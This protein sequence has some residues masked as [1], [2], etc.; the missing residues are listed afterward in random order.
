MAKVVKN[1]SVRA[2]MKTLL[3]LS[4][5]VVVSSS[6]LADVTLVQH[7]FMGASKTPMVTTMCIKGG[8]VRSDNDTT[9]SVIMDTDTGDMTTL[10]HE[11][12][13]IIKMNTKELATLAG[14][15]SGAEKAVGGTK[16]TAT[17]QKEKIDGYDC[18]LYLSENM[19]M[20]VKMWLTEDY[21]GYEKLREELKVMAKM[22]AANAP[23]QAPMPGI[24]IKTEYEQQGFKFETR[25]VSLKD[26]PVEEAKFAIPAGYKAPG[27]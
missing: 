15:A 4:L 2:C 22:S 23:E 25:L 20:V 26:G 13:M 5:A 3:S 7:T 6:A 18:E 14:A 1:V 16:V 8:K 11:Q 24:A 12:K 9:S 19:G 17:G 27:E 21:P 10:V